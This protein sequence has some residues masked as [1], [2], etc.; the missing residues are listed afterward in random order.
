MPCRT[1]V[2]LTASHHE[3]L[4]RIYITDAASLCPRASRYEVLIRICTPDA[5]L[6]DTCCSQNI[7]TAKKPVRVE[8]VG[9]VVRTCEFEMLVLPDIPEICVK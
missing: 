9:H 5:V 3:V 4:L 6:Y 2:Q 7:I 8:E 1:Y